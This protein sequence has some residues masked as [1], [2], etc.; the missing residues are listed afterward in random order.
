VDLP[1]FALHAVAFP[2]VDLPLR[3][4]EPR[5]L[6]LLDDLD[7]DRRFV[8]AAIRSGSEVG[9]GA[10]PYRV[11]VRVAIVRLERGDDDVLLAVRGQ[12]RVALIER[13]PDDRPYPCW[14]VE[15]YPDEGGAGTDDVEAT[16]RACRAYLRATGESDPHPVIPLDPVRASWALAAAAPGLVPA[17]QALLEAPGA[18]DRLRATRDTFRAE[19][20]LVRALGAGLAAS[21]AI[22][23]SPN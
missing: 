2:E 10:E 20:R 13:L 9:G 12:E 3:V 8:V 21:T 14:R 16:A 22:D 7:V 23:V 19:S 15:D 18:G 11:G 5:Y 6:A 4:F 1:V 17:R